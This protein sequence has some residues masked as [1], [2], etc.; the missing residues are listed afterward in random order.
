M[1]VYEIDDLPR[2]CCRAERMW[3]IH[4]SDQ[5]FTASR[6]EIAKAVPFLDVMGVD[7]L[8]GSEILLLFESQEEMQRHFDLVVGD[9]GPTASN[10]YDGHARVYAYTISDEG[11]ILTENT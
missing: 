4:L 3:G 7:F 9:D 11:Q 2:H 8:K 1:R 5:E 10:N 6:T